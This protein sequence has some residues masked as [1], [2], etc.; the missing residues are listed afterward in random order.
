MFPTIHPIFYRCFEKERYLISEIKPTSSTKI[1]ILHSPSAKFAKGSNY[2]LPVIDE[3]S[4]L[5]QIEFV[6]QNK[7]PRHEVLKAMQECDIYIDQIV[8]G[9]YASAAIEAMAFGKPVIAYI[10][11]R[12]FEK[13]IPT[14]CPIINANPSNLKDKLIESIENKEFRD[15][16]GKE[17][18]IYV[19]KFHDAEIESR[20]LITIYNYSIDKL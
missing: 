13:G 15:L 8:L 3:L 10:M 18:R 1:R 20:K 2:I 9:S 17:G 7:V 12:V 5:Y 4:K 6:I 11:P 16:K 14:D 19:E